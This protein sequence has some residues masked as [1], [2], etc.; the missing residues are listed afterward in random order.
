MKFNKLHPSLLAVPKNEWSI[1]FD[2]LK[3]SSIKDLHFDVMEYDYV[4]NTAFSSNDLKDIPNNF[5][6]WVHIMAY[7][8]E[9]FLKEFIYQENVHSIV[10]QYEPFKDEYII[11]KINEIKNN[12]KLA[13]IAIKPKSDFNEF[14]KIIKYCDHLV[15]MGVEPGFGGQQLIPESL[16]NLKKIVSYIKRWK[17][18]TTIE[19]DG[20]INAEWYNKLENKVTYLVSG[21]FFY[22]FLMKGKKDND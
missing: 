13:G 3:E 14:K 18:K 21:T 10:F 7:N 2:K 11:E 12:N 1:F 6:N 15:V 17:L 22:K 9:P 4:K 5:R 8:L 20:G 16:V 19:F